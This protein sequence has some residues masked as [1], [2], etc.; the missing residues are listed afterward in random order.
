[1]LG[2]PGNTALTEEE[3]RD[4]FKLEWRSIEEVKD[5]FNT[6]KPTEYTDRFISLRDKRIIKYYVSQ[7]DF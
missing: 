7:L 2:K 1:M 4:G 3:E 5:L 6:D